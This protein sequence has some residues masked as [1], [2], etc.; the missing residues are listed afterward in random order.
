MYVCSVWLI[1]S[2]S[3]LIKKWKCRTSS[4]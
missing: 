1:S 2:S 3:M 4:R